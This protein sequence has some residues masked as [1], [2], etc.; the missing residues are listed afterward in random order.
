MPVGIVTHRTNPSMAISTECYV[1]NSG[2]HQRKLAV[3]AKALRKLR[4][5]R[6]ANSLKSF[7]S[8]GG[9]HGIVGC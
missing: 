4:S 8:F 7:S 6:F 3:Y 2:G 5:R 1:R 9:M